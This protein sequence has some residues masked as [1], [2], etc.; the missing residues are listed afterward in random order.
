MDL[1]KFGMENRRHSSAVR[2]RLA[3]I[4]LSIAKKKADII[5]WWTDL[6]KI[7]FPKEESDEEFL[8]RLMQE[9]QEKGTENNDKGRG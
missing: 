1:L 7:E 6:K 9:I 3:M 8:K 5:E 2:R 4:A